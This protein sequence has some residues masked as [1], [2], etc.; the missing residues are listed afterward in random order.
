MSAIPPIGAVSGIQAPRT[1]AVDSARGA[2]F[3]DAVMR[4]LDSV[5]SLERQADRAVA[6]FAAGGD[7]QITDVMAATSKAN[8]GM[9]ILNEIRTR[10]L[11]AYQQIINTQV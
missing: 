5:A 10:G 8:L 3:G 6:T 11:E 4:G 1:P 2:G 7:V 9:T